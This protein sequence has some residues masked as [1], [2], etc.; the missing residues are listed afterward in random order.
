MGSCLPYFVIHTGTGASVIAHR[1][2][3]TTMRSRSLDMQ[4]P[5]LSAAGNCNVPLSGLTSYV[6][7]CLDSSFVGERCL[8]VCRYSHFLQFVLSFLCIARSIIAWD[9]L[10]GVGVRCDII[11]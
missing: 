3:V 4:T 7:I 9:L 5:V 10:P 11:P 6:L 8:Y 1:C 2:E